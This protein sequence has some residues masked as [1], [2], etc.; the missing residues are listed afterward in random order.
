VFVGSSFHLFLRLPEM[1]VQTRQ[2]ICVLGSVPVTTN[3][4]MAQLQ[5]IDH[6][7]WSILILVTVF[8]VMGARGSVVVKVL[9]Y[10]PEGRGF[11]TR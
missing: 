9:C 2:S 6:L 10:K 4:H 7:F 1:L 5:R 8:M 11:D 3:T